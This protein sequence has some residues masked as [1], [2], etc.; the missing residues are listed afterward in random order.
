ML[1]RQPPE[2]EEPAL[3][4]Q[5]LRSI[6]LA[7]VDLADNLVRCTGRHRNRDGGEELVP[8]AP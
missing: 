1:A 6:R 3:V 4:C 8:L 2:P 7:C 5:L